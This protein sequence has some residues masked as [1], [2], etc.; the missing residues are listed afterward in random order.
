MAE[1]WLARQR[2]H[3]GIERMVVLKRALPH[4]AA[5][6]E[7]QQMFLREARISASLDHPN[8]AS[9]YDSGVTPDGRSYLAMEY[10]HG[11]DL[12]ELLRAQAGV[13]IPLQHALTIAT[14]L[15]AA[16]DYVHARC[17]LDGRHLGLV[18]RDVS[19]SNVL[20]SFD[21][22]IKL[23]DFGVARADAASLATRSGAV[24]GKLAYMAPEQA[25]GL[26]LDPRADLYSLGVILYEMTVGQRP[27]GRTQD[28]ALLYRLLEEAPPPPIT[29]VPGFPPELSS[30]IS[31]LLSR[32]RSARYTQASQV[33]AELETFAANNRLVLSGPRL[34]EHVT[35][36]CGVRPMP[37]TSI[38]GI[39]SAPTEGLDKVQSVITRAPLAPP[40]K[41]MLPWLLVGAAVA[42]VTLGVLAL[43]IPQWSQTPAPSSDP[44]PAVLP[45]LDDAPAVG[46]SPSALPQDPHTADASPAVD[47]PPDVDLSPAADSLP[48]PDPPRGAAPSR[49]ADS[50]APDSRP[51][52]DPSPAD[53]SPAADPSPDTDTSSDTD[54]SPEALEPSQSDSSADRGTTDEQGTDDIGEDP[55][56]PEPAPASKKKRRGKKKRPPKRSL[57]SPLPFG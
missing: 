40:R 49:T 43:A 20:L 46:A 54:A 57:D 29:L 21:G 48:D 9:V 15:C 18:H 7:F 31:C 10:V 32:D 44:A 30:L 26:S 22:A 50:G 53:P 8:I 13:P 6:P 38:P 52:A 24:K 56:P 55:I 51:A 35:E 45:S 42:G 12:H 3:G 19:P 2:G 1:L 34:G 11:V 36:H 17:D 41:P 39:A 14:G 5:D 47:P 37:S 33:R 4:N 27:F 28:V 25:R 16:L 23:T